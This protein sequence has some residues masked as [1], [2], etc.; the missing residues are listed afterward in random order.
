MITVTPQGGNTNYKYLS[1][2][3]VPAAHGIN[4][5]AV[6][7]PAGNFHVTLSSLLLSKCAIVGTTVVEV[8]ICYFFINNN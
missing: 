8:I 4:L 6:L 5:I 2:K 1:L 3:S 7:I